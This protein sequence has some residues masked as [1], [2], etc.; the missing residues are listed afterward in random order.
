MTPSFDQL[1]DAVVRE[2]Y[3]HPPATELEIA[4]FEAR[5]GWPLGPELRAFYLRCNGAEL[6]APL[7]EANYSILSL[8]EVQRARIRMRGTDDDS[9]SP[10][11]WWVLV[12]CQDSDFILV[13]ASGR[14]P[15]PMLDAFHETFPQVKQVAASFG[16][17]LSRALTSRNRLY[18]L[19]K[20]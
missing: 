15:Y 6:F 3:P 1:L 19:Q 14:A 5:A 2:H 12:D 8:G 11:T 16:E 13:D 20:P 17:F 9:V 18:W 7:P 4:A 10:G